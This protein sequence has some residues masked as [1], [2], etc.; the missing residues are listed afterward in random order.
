MK[1]HITI[2]FTVLFCLVSLAQEET[3]N[4]IESTTIPPGPNAAEFTRHNFFEA[5]LYRGLPGVQIPVHEIKLKDFSLPVSLTYNYDGF[6]P[7]QVASTCGLG[8]N[9][10]AGGMITRTVHGK[11]DEGL[12]G[13]DDVKTWL[14]IPDPIDNPNYLDFYYSMT[15]E[16]K[17]H[18][19]RKDWDGIPDEFYLS[20][21][22][23][24]AKLIK[25]ND[26]SYVTIPYQ[27][28]Q[29]TRET[30]YTLSELD[31]DKW[32]IVG[33]DGTTYILGRLS[34]A[35]DYGVEISLATDVGENTYISVW[36]VREIITPSNK[37]IYFEYDTED[38]ESEP[39][40][41]Y[42]QYHIHR[43]EAA[44]GGCAITNTVTTSVGVSHDN[45]RLSKIIAP[46]EIVDFTS[47]SSRSDIKPAN[48][49]KKLDEIVIYSRKDGL[50]DER[51]K[52][53]KLGYSYL[54]NTAAYNTCRLILDSI[55]QNGQD[56]N[57]NLPSYKFNY[58]N[59][60]AAI[61]TFTDR[62]MDH[63]GYY[64]NK[65]NNTLVPDNIDGSDFNEYF[66]GANRN[67]DH[68]E[69]NIGL[70][71][72]IEYPEGGWTQ[73]YYEPNDF[74]ATSTGL[75]PERVVI[76]GILTTFAEVVSSGSI[77]EDTE[78]MILDF[79]QEV[80]LTIQTSYNGYPI[81]QDPPMVKLIRFPDT[82]LETWYGE[83]DETVFLD[84]EAGRYILY[85]FAM[86]NGHSA[87][88]EARYY[89]AVK[90]GGEVV[91]TKNKTAGG[92]RLSKI[93]EVD[94]NGV[95]KTKTFLYNVSSETDRSS[96]V[97]SREPRYEYFMDVPKTDRIGS[98]PT[99]IGECTYVCRVGQSIVPLQSGS[100]HIGYREVQ[101]LEGIEG[102]YGRTHY[103]YTSFL[104]NPDIV[105]PKN[106]PSISNEHKRGK[107]LKQEV[108]DDNENLVSRTTNSYKRFYETGAPNKYGILGI[109][110]LEFIRE[111]EQCANDVF[112]EP[113][114]GIVNSEW[115][116]LDYTIQ[117]DC[118][119]GNCISTITQYYYDNPEHTLPTR[120]ET[121]LEDGKKLT[122]YTLY[123]HDYINT[124]NIDFIDKMRDAHIL[125]KPVESISYQE[126]NG[127][128]HIL[129]GTVNIY[130]DLLNVGF[131][132]ESYVLELE[133]PLPK[134]L[135]KVSNRTAAGDLF[136]DEGIIAGFNID[137]IDTHYPDAGDPTVS[138]DRYD[139]FYNIIQYH[140][141]DDINVSIYWAYDNRY[142]IIKAENIH[143]TVLQVAVDNALGTAYNDIDHFLSTIER[144]DSPAKRDSLERFNED[145]R[146]YPGLK[147]AVITTYTYVPLIGTTSE[148]NA[149][150]YTTYYIYDTF[151]RLIETRDKDYNILQ[152]V[153]YH[154]KNE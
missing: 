105:F 53:M 149:M 68:T 41:A 106:T 63:W 133:N 70:L 5:N 97:I 8:W 22:N 58:T 23:I 61:P 151:G 82:E 126:K 115:Q 146:N 57:E 134:S 119:S 39:N 34:S 103:Y 45:H 99:C 113:Y 93:E 139:L 101:V 47:V 129:S 66:S 150:G 48:T 142:P 154:Y 65:T 110:N 131:L 120:V 3:L 100:S 122:S 118:F 73:F 75:N 40:N 38:I 109:Y 92:F 123:P 71:E 77:I 79:D 19:A 130:D 102:E 76:A 26:D 135:F 33:A 143:Y 127:N 64:N 16:Q 112:T 81:Q 20:I 32:T 36:Y 87:R 89:E 124:I 94:E 28:L 96:G 152:T 147:D 18:L 85:A 80:E 46:N 111:C 69:A 90:E 12:N 59:E 117:E 144:L 114:F 7:G 51:I 116:V 60:S 148:T 107:L 42:V 4:L 49:T 55:Q 1:L 74:G 91:T 128:I 21:G 132:K 24:S 27:P 6:K 29:I 30:S 153:D 138:I 15:N 44:G 54:G 104:S 35:D 31:Y 43:D 13:Y 136:P 108:Y 141:S 140:K 88:I 25:L 98:I 2:G 145:L 121:T 67:C 56:P 17:E 10:N 95:Q 52:S 86:D 62:G 11:P 14:G 37:H 137:N 83:V 84:L 125:I 9:L 72:K 50:Q 78:A